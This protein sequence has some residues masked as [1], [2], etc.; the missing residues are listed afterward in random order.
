[1]RYWG[2]VEGGDDG[3]EEETLQS[4]IYM[5]QTVLPSSSR[6]FQVS[7]HFIFNL[8]LSTVPPHLPERVLM[9]LLLAPESPESLWQYWPTDAISHAGLNKQAVNATCL[10]DKHENKN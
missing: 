10:D 5:L 3:N 7:S 9:M 1:M 4:V 8:S 6:T 2:C